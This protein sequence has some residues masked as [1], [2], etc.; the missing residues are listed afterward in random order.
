M[1]FMKKYAGKIQAVILIAAIFVAGFAVGTINSVSVAQSR[2]VIGDTDEAFAPLWEVFNTIQ[3]SYVDSADIDVPLLVNGAITGMVESLGDR[4]S[5]YIDPSAFDRFNSDLSGNFEGIGVVIETNPDTNEI[6]VTNVLRGSP[7]LG[8]G[9]LPGDIFYSVDGTLIEGLDQTALALL[10]LGPAGSTVNITFKRGTEL[11]NLAIV[12]ARIELPNVETDILDNNIAY[13]SLNNF[14]SVAVNQIR[15][16]LEEVDVNNRNGL[17]FDLRGNPGGLL[18]SAIDVGSLFIRD[19]VLLY[20][21]F[22]DGSEQTFEVNGNYANINVPIVV[23]VNENS[24]S[25][26]ELVAGAIKDRGA[27]TLIGETTFGKGTVQTIQPLSNGGGLRLTIARY[28]LPSRQ[29]I[30]DVGVVP[31]I[32]IDYDPFEDGATGDLQLEAAIRFLSESTSNTPG[33]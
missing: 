33:N 3:A 17:V 25:A 28:L 9:V 32:A 20:E 10:V 6:Y 15:Q 29:W 19:G 31:D 4:Y 7:A 13:V 23:L 14:N 2:V 26:S 12:R 18:S 30:H 11:I 8:A 24:A 5:N 22:A 1:G 21:T 16:A 27:G